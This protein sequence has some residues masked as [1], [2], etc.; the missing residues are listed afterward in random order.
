[1]YILLRSGGKS[2]CLV[3]LNYRLFNLVDFYCTSEIDSLHRRIVALESLVARIF[4]SFDIDNREL[5][6]LPQPN[7]AAAENVAPFLDAPG[8]KFQTVYDSTKFDSSLGW[9]DKEVS[10]RAKRKKTEVDSGTED[11]WYAS[12]SSLVGWDNKHNTESTCE[13]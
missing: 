13:L 1:M 11:W 5:G 2:V 8:Q 7:E 10:C 4:L 9:E 12:S 3:F 6:R